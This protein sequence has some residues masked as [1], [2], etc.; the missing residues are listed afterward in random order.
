[1]AQLLERSPSSRVLDVAAGPGAL[2][3]HLAH[4]FGCSVVGVDHRRGLVPSRRLVRGAARSDS[5]D[6]KEAAAGAGLADPGGLLVLGGLVERVS[7]GH[8]REL[9]Q[10][11]S[12]WLPLPLQAH[13]PAT[14]DQD[15]AA[16]SLDRGRG[17]GGVL[18]IYLWIGDLNVSDQVGGHNYTDSE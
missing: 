7:L 13:P 15:A 8:R 3:H 16:I 11:Q 10:G 12:V 18:G 5:F 9:N 14:P 2:A 4:V 17:E 1:M 6:E